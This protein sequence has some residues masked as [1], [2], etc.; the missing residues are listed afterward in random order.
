MK[1]VTLIQMM[2]NVTMSVMKH[3]NELQCT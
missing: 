3:V 1:G 2:S